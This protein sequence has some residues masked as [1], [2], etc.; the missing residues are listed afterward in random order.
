MELFQNYFVSTDDL[1]GHLI[2]VFSFN[3]LRCK[4]YEKSS[5]TE[6]HISNN[7]KCD[8]KFPLLAHLKK[9]EF[10]YFKEKTEFVKNSCDLC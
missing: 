1:I 6:S 3:C 8:Q 4:N 5:F 2:T 7:F 10:G 9:T